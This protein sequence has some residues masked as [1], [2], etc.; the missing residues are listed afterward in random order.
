MTTDPFVT[1]AWL[2]E[3]LGDPNLV[4]VDG[5]WYLP[6]V[7]RDPRAEYLAG[8]IPGAIWFDVD[9]YADLSTTLP[10]MLMKPAEFGALAGRLGISETDTIV[11]Y[12]GLGL[13]SAP[14][15]RWNF[16]VMG[17][18]DVRILSG[19]LPAW[20]AEKR[21][22]ETEEVAHP[23]A[24]F[25][26]DFE[27]SRVALIEDMQ[28]LV[29]TG[30]RQIIDARPQGR[31]IGSDAEPRAG[32]RSGHM[33]NAISAPAVSLVENGK[34]KSPD[35]LKAQFA[36]AGIDLSKP[37]VTTCGSG[38]TAATLKLALEQAGA[39]DVILYDGSWTEWAGRDDTE[40][41]TG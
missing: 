11:V 32:L 25:N 18:R 12:D 24:T 28:T 8:H 38:V 36:A 14:R 15:V 6:A 3:H 37:I 19:G 29:R 7:A 22:L 21:P 41:V 27:P 40:V 4:V 35:A 16:M 2:A 1:P 31:F 34:L 10:H 20:V 13:S 5:S 39:T 23:I 26:V 9:K 33:P 30:D 17:A